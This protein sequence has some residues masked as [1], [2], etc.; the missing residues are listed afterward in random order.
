[1]VS[2]IKQ[3][4]PPINVLS[5][6]SRGCSATASAPQF[7]KV[8]V[9]AYSEG[10]S[11]LV[12][13]DAY[14]FV[15]D[16]PPKLGGKG[17]GANP[18]SLLLGSLI[19][20]TQFTSLMIQKELGMPEIKRALWSANGEYNLQGVQGKEGSDAK[21]HNI[22][23]TGTLETEASEEELRSLA[24]QIKQR[25]VIGSTLSSAGTN[26]SVQLNKGHVAHDCQPA[27]EL[28]AFQK[29]NGGEFAH[30]KDTP[31]E[32][33]DIPK[34]VSSSPPSDGS[35]RGYHTSRPLASEGREEPDGEEIAR[36]H[37]HAEVEPQLQKGMSDKGAPETAGGAYAS[38]DV[39]KAQGVPTGES[40]KK[41][42][43][44]QT[45]GTAE[46]REDDPALTSGDRGLADKGKSPL[47]N[48]PSGGG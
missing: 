37:L 3:A 12:Q 28:H 43:Q 47:G 48:Q 25:N 36:Q 41:V 21:L 6:T 38:R 13:R 10:T 39:P 24:S 42:A 44:N 26:I 23:V 17:L 9:D 31:T 7:M 2:R 29:S 45:A 40:N 19:G 34:P 15:V 33:G 20:C 35:R 46:P 1:M 27:C 18:V 16:E 32:S 22:T 5:V 4:C 11:T 8:E 14:S 30:K